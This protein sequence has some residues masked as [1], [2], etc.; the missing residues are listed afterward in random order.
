M[1]LVVFCHTDWPVVK[2]W[3]LMVAAPLVPSAS[4]TQ[5]TPILPA[6]VMEVLS[7]QWSNPPL[8]S[9]WSARLWPVR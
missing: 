1:G 6:A 8:S 4:H 7:G 9:G 3:R 5:V 2:V